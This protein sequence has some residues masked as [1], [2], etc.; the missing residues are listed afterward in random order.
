VAITMEQHT[1]TALARRRHITH[2][3]LICVGIII[4]VEDENL[5]IWRQ[6]KWCVQAFSDQAIIAY[7]N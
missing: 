1:S 5:E 7:A 6:V 2:S 3:A 4:R